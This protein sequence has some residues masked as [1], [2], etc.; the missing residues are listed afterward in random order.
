MFGISII[1]FPSEIALP[2][3]NPQLFSGIE[4]S[5][6]LIASMPRQLDI[7]KFKSIFFAELLPQNVTAEIVQQ[8]P[9]IINGFKQ[10]MHKLL[11]SAAFHNGRAVTIDFGVESCFTNSERRRRLI[12]LISLLAADLLSNKITL[13]LPVRV[14]FMMNTAAE[15]YLAFKRELL[16]PNVQFSLD[17]HPHEMAGRNIHLYELLHWLQFDLKCVKFI[18]E[19]ETGNRLTEKLLQNWLEFFKKIRFRGF[20]FFRPV[21]MVPDVFEHEITLLEKI[22]PELKKNLNITTASLANSKH[23][24]FQHHEVNNC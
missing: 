10:E 18:Y 13:L 9:N 11:E 2:A 22:I 14:P 3:F 16:C 5:E 1:N 21:T 15:D 17:I 4:L 7:H 24:N 23:Y 6:S 12:K 19:P 20:I 8:S